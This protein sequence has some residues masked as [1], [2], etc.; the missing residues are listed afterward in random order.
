MPSYTSNSEQS[1]NNI[2]YRA[3]PQNDWSTI[4]IVVVIIS[5]ISIAM[6]EFFAR[7]MDH[8]AGTYQSGF[9]EMWAQ[10]R[11]KLD[12]PHD[13]N[14]V[15]TGSSRI[16]WASDLNILENGFE[17]RP[18][19]LAL[20]G[21]SPAIF[22]EDIVNNTDFDGL[23]IVGVTPFLVNWIGPG[24]FGG[25]A[26]DFYHSPSPAGISSFYI[27]NFLSDYFAFLDEAFSLPELKN[28]YIQLPKREGSKNLNEQGWKL[29]DVYV[30]RQTDMWAPVEIEGSFDNQQMLNFWSPGIDLE[31][32]IP[33][34]KQQKINKSLI[35]FF[36]PLVEKQ[37]DRGG[38]IVFIRMAS[39]GD[40][41][42]EELLNNYTER[43]WLPFVKQLNAPYLDTNN[44]SELSTDLEIPEWSH[45]SRKS[46]DEWSER[47]V[48]HVKRVY[49]EFHNK[50]LNELLNKDKSNNNLP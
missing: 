45:L 20:P 16:L 6:W 46:Q 25:P 15:I 8:T 48:P 29:G 24:F 9:K 31:N 33:D 47:V 17:T 23:I 32:P 5:L 12:E 36:K 49:E 26:L 19:Q 35:D 28:N 37:R 4:M 42:K 21:T 1:E 38:D 14:V 43:F 22:V 44:F 30:D 34:E 11:R 2:P 50:P 10:E 18:L 3:I 13:I 39:S 7:S 41:R 40:Y 27:H